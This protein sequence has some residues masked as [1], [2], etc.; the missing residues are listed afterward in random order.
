[1]DRATRK[2]F[3]IMLVIMAAEGV[4]MAITFA[5][6]SHAAVVRLYAFSPAIW[7]AWLATAAVAIAYSLYSIRAMPLIGARFFEAHWLKLLAVPF[8]LISGTM[9]ELW[10]RRLAMDAAAAHGLKPAAQVALSAISFGLVHAMWGLFARRWRVALGAGIATAILGL[11][12][13]L[14]FLLGGR[15]VAPCIWAHAAINLAIEPWL[16][17]AAIS[18]GKARAAM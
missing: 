16:L 18:G 9:E 5:K 1:M 7:P 8:A 11:L 12:L 6:S 17:V 15:Q 4:P 13:A 10:F 3:A 14:V 2:T